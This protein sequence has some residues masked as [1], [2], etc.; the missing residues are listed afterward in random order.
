MK[1]LNLHCAILLCCCS[2]VVHAAPV[3]HHGQYVIVRPNSSSVRIVR[4][5]VVSDEIVRVQATSAECLPEKAQSLMIVNQKAKPNYEVNQDGNFVYVKTAK[6]TTVVDQSTGVVSFYDIRGKK[7]LGETQNGKCFW[8]YRVP[9]REIGVDSVRVTETQRNGLSWQLSFEPSDDALYGLGQHQSEELNMR[10]KNEDLFQYNTKVSVPFVIS[11]KGYGIL[12]DSYS[13]CRFGQSEDYLQLNRAFCLYDKNGIEGGLT[14]TYTDKDGR[15]LVRQEDSIYYEY[16]MPAKQRLLDD[17]GIQNLPENFNL[18]GATVVYE[19][20]IEPRSSSLISQFILYYAGYIKVYINGELVVPERWRT[21]WNPNTYKFVANVPEG[22]KTPLR[23][24]WR[25][26]GAVSYCGLRVAK[27]RLNEERKQL[28]IWSEMAQDMDYYFIAGASMDEV[29]SGYRLLTG[30]API[31]PKWVLGYWQSRE[32]FK[33][34]KEVM[35][36]LNEF[37][38]QHLPIDNIVQDWNYWEE[39]QWGSHQFESSRYPDPQQMIDSIHQMHGRF[40][41][42]VWPKFYCNTDN[43]KQLD[44]KGWMYHQAVAD[45]IRDWVGPGY[46]GSFYDAYDPDAR[47]LFWHQMDE[48]LYSG[49][50]LKK[51]GGKIDAW[52]MDASEPNVR[53]CTPMWYRKVLCGP[54]ALG[55][56]TEYFNAYAL[57]NA[58]AIYEGQRNS[59]K[60]NSKLLNSQIPEPRVFL[61]TRS[62]FAGLQRYSTAT[63]SGDIGTRWED[64]RA[65]MTAGMNYSLSG[66]PFWGM[67]IG[68]F[69]VENRYV[70]AQNFFDKTGREN[71]DLREWRELQTRWLQFGTFV[72]LFRVHGQWPLREPW[73][74]APKGHPAYQ[75]FVYYDRLRYR[76]MPYLYSMAGWV[77]LKDYTMMRALA[78]DFGDDDC[79]LDIKDQ[80]MFGPSLMACPVS[81][82]KARNRS[83]YFPKGRGW[84][85][86]YTGKMVIGPGDS[87]PVRRLVA[88]APY[89]RIPVFVPEGSIIPFGPEMEWSDEKP[90]ELI[91]LFV[92]GG[93]DAQFTLYEDEGTN[94]NYEKGQYA[95]IDIRFD[96]VTKTVTFGKRKGSFPEM[97]Q[98]RRFSIVFIDKDHPHPLN[99]D[100]SKGHVVTYKGKQITVDVQ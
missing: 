15:T 58:Q 28:T 67:D 47:K 81:E 69:C 13:Y 64:M 73:N 36:T 80:W 16:D 32:R 21:A 3:E 37:R 14:A 1:F 97:L 60:V 48:N 65:Q 10:G 77:H 17:G 49:L 63:W 100:N 50:A 95:T 53:D 72:P 34:Q 74:I 56:S 59:W 44:A 78:M 54:T 90:A 46:I 70:K 85:D 29:I 84:Y 26:D 30:R 33:T 92:Y 41:I 76:L 43:Y 75:S 27:P 61:L 23:I 68:G 55:T 93:R 9:D 19:G 66:L 38:R 12:W 35:G 71:D 24:E 39:D 96:E 52:W 22:E 89:D 31:Y 4:L 86:L 57:V 94:Y 6:L 79:V 8:P 99:L 42:S 40:M 82:Y 2:M 25:P 88:D 83:V 45:S 62:G 5:Q 51:D 98:Q 11:P 7:I 18:D 87:A 91:H 20:F